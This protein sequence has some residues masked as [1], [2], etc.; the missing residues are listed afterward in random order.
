MSKP[1]SSLFSLSSF[2]SPRARCLS[3]QFRG[4]QLQ[5]YSRNASSNSSNSA[6]SK[7]SR[8]PSDAPSNNS[9]R[10]K[11]H[12]VIEV[13]KK[14]EFVPKPLN[15]PLGLP[16][17]PREGQ[18]TGIDTR[19]LRQRRDD[20]VDHE[21]H[22]ERRKYLAAQAAKPYFREWT[23]M[24]YHKGKT[25]IANSRLFR[26][27]KSLY[28]P[29]LYGRTLSASKPMQ[30]TTPILRGKVSV[31]SIFS[32]LWAER[33]VAS[34]V[35]PQSNPVLHQILKEKPRLAQRVEINFEDNALKAWLIRMF[36]W[37]MRRTFPEVQH[38]RY[39]LVTKGLD[40]GLREKIGMMNSKVGYVY[41]LD[42][43]CRIRWAG[44]SIAEKGEV[45]SLNNGLRR[46]LDDQRL[47]AGIDLFRQKED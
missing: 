11:K 3:C 47:Q 4:L 21:K 20:F 18:N 9:N 28:F 29:N 30:D 15:R 25:F 33:Q 46:L 17:L 8:Q 34:F 12:E 13:E 23:N 40:E 31:V 27:D 36:M 10:E 1:Q 41:L 32:S 14:D 39:F 7:G 38:D 19:T 24:R 37:R 44:S 2:L 6:K 35:S 16:Y 43:E 45:E 42:Q 5:L 26:D 22:L